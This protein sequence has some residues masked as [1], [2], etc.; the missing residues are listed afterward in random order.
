[1]FSASYGRNIS[2]YYFENFAMT[3]NNVVVVFVVVDD[4]ND[5]NNVWYNVGNHYP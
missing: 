4:D 1:M 3:L 2:K 5:N